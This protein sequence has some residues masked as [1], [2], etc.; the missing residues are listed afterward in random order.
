MNVA[1]PP[2]PGRNQPLHDLRGAPSARSRAKLNDRPR[3]YSTDANRIRRLA[4]QNFSQ[5]MTT[6]EVILG[7]DAWFGAVGMILAG[8]MIAT[9]TIVGAES[10]VTSDLPTNVMRLRPGPRGATVEGVYDSKS[11]MV[12][13]S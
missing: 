4:D 11:L 7:D 8:A 1:Y 3:R 2:K 9:G 6:A 10:V 5:P 13:G 12:D